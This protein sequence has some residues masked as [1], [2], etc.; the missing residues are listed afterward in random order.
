MAKTAAK[1]Q[2]KESKIGK[3]RNKFEQLVAQKTAI[4]AGMLSSAVDSPNA[5]MQLQRL[6]GNRQVAEMLSKTTAQREQLDPPGRGISKE[7][8]SYW[9]VPDGTNQ[10]YMVE[11]EQ[12]TETSFA[13]VEKT[14]GALKDG[15]G[16]IQIAE[17]DVTGTTHS[18][19]RKQA[20]EY[21]G[22]L[23]SRP[24]GRAL[25]MRLMNDESEQIT[26]RPSASRKVA[27]AMPDGD[28]Q[29]AFIKHDGTSSDGTDSIVE[30][31]P[32]LKDDS[33]IVFDKDGNPIDAPVFLILG[34]E[35]IHAEN[36]LQGD[37]Q[38]G[39]PAD[40]DAYTDAE[41]EAAIAGTTVS[42]N[43][44]RAEHGYEERFGHDAV[45]MR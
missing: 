3:K 26:I 4:Q 32:D 41:E 39:I 8:G 22:M 25:I 13:K 1:Q 23:M 35:L 15:S 38:L 42:E 12:I 21:I 18:G 28:E 14:W 36:H 40:D 24:I 11:G 34:H 10:S 29:N 27:E 44:L 19:F 20:I 17:K 37:G 9:V 30:I 16:N 31:D 6:L 2:K 33:V 5:M 7:F 43:M 45:D